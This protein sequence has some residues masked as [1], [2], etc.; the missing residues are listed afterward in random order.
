MLAILVIAIVLL[1]LL[2]SVVLLQAETARHAGFCSARLAAE[3]QQ[4]S[5]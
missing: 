5:T 4:A 3:C 2:I 1:M